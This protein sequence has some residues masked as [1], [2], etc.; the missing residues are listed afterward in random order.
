MKKTYDFSK[1][2]RGALIDKKRYSITIH[3][4][5]GKAAYKVFWRS[6]S[7][8]DAAGFLRSAPCIAEAWEQETSEADVRRDAYTKRSLCHCI[9]FLRGGSFEWVVYHTGKCGRAAKKATA[10]KNCERELR[11][12]MNYVIEE[13]TK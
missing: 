2:K 9:R 3:Y 6:L 7:V 12:S 5:D 10:R 11:K 8:T 4:K 1:A 13:P